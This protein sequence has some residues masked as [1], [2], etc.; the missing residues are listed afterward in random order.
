MGFFS[1]FS[2]SKRENTSQALTGRKNILGQI[3]TNFYTSIIDVSHTMMLYFSPGEG[4]IGAN[5]TF[6]E[7]MACDRMSEYS[8]EYESIRD[9]FVS[10]SEEIFTESDKSWLDYIKRYYKN[11]YALT[12]KNARDEILNIKAYCHT[13][14]EHQNF[15]VLELEDVTAL[16]KSELQTAE[17]EQL[18]RKYIENIGHEF[19]TPIN[20]ILGFIELLGQTNLDKHQ[21]EYLQMIH[22]SSRNL[23]A[24]IETLLDL[25]QLQGGQ[26]ELDKQEFNL[27]PEMEELAYN[28][29]KAGVDKGIKVMTFI[30][31]KIPKSI[32]SDKKKINQI[33]FSLGQNAIKFTPHGGKVIIEVKL[34][35]RNQ[36]GECSIGFGI[37]DNGQAISHEQIAKIDEPFSSGNH[38]DERLSVG[39]TFSD[40]LVKLLGSKLKIQSK[41]ESGTYMNFVLDCKANLEQNYKMVPKTKVKVLLLDQSKLEEANFLTIY[42]RSF[43]IDVIK[44]NQLDK[45]VYDGIDALY[46]I[47]NDDD[48]SWMLELGSYSKKVPLILLLEEDAK[49]QTKLIHIVNEVLSKPLLP[50]SIATHLYSMNSIV[51]T[52]QKVETLHIKSETKAL[53]VEDNLINQRLI[54]ILLEG[55]AIDVITAV[56]GLEAVNQSTKYQFDIIFMDIDMPEKNGIDATREIKEGKSINRTTPIVALTA[57]ATEGDKKMLIEK[58]LDDYLSKPLTRDKLETILHKYLKVTSQVA[59]E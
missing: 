36:N 43:G 57:M 20:G 1:L 41:E 9:M 37:R 11:G 54:Q 30:D 52:T 24:N 27:L 56:N 50:S 5:K 49:L 17:V 22:N 40:A 53:V 4:W 48:S 42:L 39:L 7:T 59:A 28:F 13:F 35:K 19:R 25:S 8:G 31:P 44:S 34:L 58:G 38:D 6:F 12:L 14:K 3:D 55:Y 46:I 33:V 10:E 21:D 2:S 15:Y 45:Y 29:G 32:F 16:Y 47:A 51:T 18:R 23:M 26:L